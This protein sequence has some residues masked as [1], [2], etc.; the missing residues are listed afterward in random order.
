[1]RV[2]EVALNL[3]AKVSQHP[4]VEESPDGDG[5]EAQRKDAAELDAHICHQSLS[6]P[7]R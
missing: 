5:R 3:S 6:Q 7:H 4:A 1:M 2:P